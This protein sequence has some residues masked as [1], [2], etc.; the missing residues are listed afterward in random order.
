MCAWWK[1]N[2]AICRSYDQDFG[3]TV[4]A[5]T[6]DDLFRE[7]RL[8][9]HQDPN[10]P[11]NV[12]DKDGNVIH[13]L[14]FI[15]VLQEEVKLCCGLRSGKEPAALLRKDW[16]FFT[17]QDG[18]FKGIKA[19]VLNKNHGNQKGKSLSLRAHTAKDSVK[20]VQHLPILKGNGLFDCY[21]MIVMQLA[22]M[23]PDSHIQ[24]LPRMFRLEASATTINVRHYIVCFIVLVVLLLCLSCLS[25]LSN[26][27]L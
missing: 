5:S 6:F 22:M 4:N 2:F 14:N 11:F 24:G 9:A 8:K 19:V 1:H 15:K 18:P 10:H 21:N 7:K 20:N 13:Y 27:L 12:F 23:P 16:T 3:G 26:I 25:C 17:V